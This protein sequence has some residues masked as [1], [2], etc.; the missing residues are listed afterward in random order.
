MVFGDSTKVF[1]LAVKPVQRFKISKKQ[2]KASLIDGI[3]YI[4]I[5]AVEITFKEIGFNII[6]GF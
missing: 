2:N 1:Q 3:F 6:K 5:Q 4:L